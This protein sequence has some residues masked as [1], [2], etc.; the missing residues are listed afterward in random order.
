MSDEIDAMNEEIDSICDK[1]DR[2]RVK[3][4]F[5][6]KE[7]ASLRQRLAESEAQLKNAAAMGVASTRLIQELEAKLSLYESAPS[8]PEVK[9][10][11]KKVGDIPCTREEEVLARAYRSC[12]AK[13]AEA[14]EIKLRMQRSSDAQ[15]ISAVDMIRDH[16]DSASRLTKEALNRAEKAESELATARAKIE[17]AGA[18]L[19]LLSQNLP[20]GNLKDGCVATLFRLGP[21]EAA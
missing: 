7:I 8:E 12:Q 3:L 5:A 13:L 16:T 1:N 18:A 14:E 10:A 4:M 17:E 2:L 11:L 20:P 6:D 15:S 21:K 9:E 19:Y